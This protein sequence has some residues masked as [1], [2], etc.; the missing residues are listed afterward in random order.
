MISAGA[1]FVGGRERRP[2]RASH[3]STRPSPVPTASVRAR[4]EIAN[5]R[6]VFRRRA[7]EALRARARVPAADGRSCGAALGGDEHAP[8]AR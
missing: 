8:V 1:T 6:S 2:V 4:G 3:H 5:G 7:L